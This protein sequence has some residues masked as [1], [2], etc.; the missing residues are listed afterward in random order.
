ML[1]GLL[2]Q[3]PLAELFGIIQTG[4]K[5]GVLIIRHGEQ[6]ARIHFE[7]GRI[8]YA[9]VLEGPNLGEYLMRME[10]L[11]ALQLQE[12]VSLQKHEN[13]DTPLGLLARNR[14]LILEDQLLQALHAQISDAVTEVLRWAQRPRTEFRFEEIGPD[15][16]QVPTEHRFDP[17]AIL[18][19]A[20]RRMDEWSQG[21]VESWQVL[22]RVEDRPG[23]LS[24]E[25]WE[26]V[27]LVDGQRSSASIA[28]EFDLAEG[29]V[30]RRLYQLV[31]RR[32]LEVLPVRPEDPFVLVVSPSATLRRLCTLLLTRARYRAV[33]AASLER[34]AA[35]L[36]QTFV[37]AAVIDSRQPLNDARTLRAVRGRAY[38]PIIVLTNETQGLRARLARLRY[39]SKPLLE[40]PFLET[41]AQVARRAL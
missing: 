19:E 35:V 6:G 26:L 1:A 10:L 32:I 2:R 8:I 30:Y 33:T 36:E 29:E 16:S 9:R 15:S 27:G 28:A 24:L 31:E 13:P 12:L 7:N 3:L 4:R 38:L 40:E 20:T 14:G 39:V 17:Q 18:L 11:D 21:Q 25:D 37:S 41:V 5:T 34:A 22:R 23:N